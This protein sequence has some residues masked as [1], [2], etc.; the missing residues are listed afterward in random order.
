MLKY[1]SSFFLLLAFIILPSFIPLGQRDPGEDV[2]IYLISNE[3]HTDLVLPVKNE[4]FDWYTFLDPKDFA[5]QPSQWLEFGW[6]DQDFYMQVPTWDE[7]TWSIMFDALFIPGPAVM[8]VNYLN[9]HPSIYTTHRR[10]TLSRDTY[11]K[12][13]NAIKDQFKQKSG[14]PLILP[15]KG[16]TKSDNFYEAYGS[17][18]ILKTCNVWTANVLGEVGLKR[19]LWSPTKYGLNFIWQAD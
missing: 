13:V 12:L 19:P 9:Q 3:I 14:K 15:G 7:F 6:G 4:V 2:E 11:A 16:Y 1:I 18:S 8:H 17:F 5:N 10:I